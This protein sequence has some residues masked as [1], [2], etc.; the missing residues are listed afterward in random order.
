MRDNGRAMLHHAL[1]LASGFILAGESVHFDGEL[2]PRFSERQRASTAESTRA[3]FAKWAATREGQAIVAR[4]RNGEREVAIIENADESGIGRAPQPSLATLLAANDSTKRKR[5][6]L[7]VN[8]SLAAQYDG[9]S[10]DLGMPRTPT[11]VMATAWAGEMLHI[12]F[13]AQGIPLPHHERADFQERWRAVAGELGFPTMEHTT[14]HW[15]AVATPR[16]STR[17]YFP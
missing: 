4:F 9:P 17:R 10:I 15:S 14:E 1:I 11:D 7:I 16:R 3:G 5:Y 13:Y 12:D 8:P 2:R 6:E